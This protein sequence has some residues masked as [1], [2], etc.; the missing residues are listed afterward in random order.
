MCQ[1]GGPRCYTEAHPAALAAQH[2]Y[3]LACSEYEMTRD[4]DQGI[5]YRTTPERDEVLRAALKVREEARIAYLGAMA[6]LYATTRGQQELD[7]MF[8]IDAD[9]PFTYEQMQEESEYRKRRGKI[10]RAVKAAAD[11][12]D[13]SSALGQTG[14]QQTDM[15]VA[16][17][18]REF[19]ADHA[20]HDIAPRLIPGVKQYAS[21][22]EKDRGVA[23]WTE[24]V[25]NEAFHHTSCIR[26]LSCAQEDV[27]MAYEVVQAEPDNAAAQQRLAETHS[28]V[29]LFEKELRAS[30]TRVVVMADKLRIAQSR[31]VPAS[32][33]VPDLGESPF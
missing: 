32:S 31:Q 7:Q 18:A 24:R 17:A 21:Q 20:T 4:R 28:L 13:M 33:P 29:P 9:F 11:T 15:I 8:G 1:T 14:D 6:D 16:Q 26:R 25:T 19:A 10:V 3:C 30:R 12:G 27:E 23:R 5:E 22:E 2:A